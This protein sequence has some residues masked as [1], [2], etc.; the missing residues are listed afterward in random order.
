MKTREFVR[1]NPVSENEM[2]MVKESRADAKE[3]KRLQD[4]LRRIEDVTNSDGEHDADYSAVCDKVN[5]MAREGLW[6]RDIE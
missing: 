4:I 2:E 6:T 3:I 5:A 1:V